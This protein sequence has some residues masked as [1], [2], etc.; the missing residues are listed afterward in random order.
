MAI[1]GLVA[2]GLEQVERQAS[3]PFELLRLE[4]A[5]AVLRGGVEAQCLPVGCKTKRV[6]SGGLRIGVRD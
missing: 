2:E 5:A 1:R 3:Q 4:A 6:R